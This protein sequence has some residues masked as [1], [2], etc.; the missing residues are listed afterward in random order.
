MTRE[1]IISAIDD[2]TGPDRMSKRQA[3]DELELLVPELK[4]RMEWLRDDIE[5]SDA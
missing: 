5:V 2:F 4:R 1:Q 3:L